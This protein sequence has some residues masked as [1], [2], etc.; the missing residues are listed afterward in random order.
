MAFISTFM[1]GEVGS[2]VRGII[3]QLVGV[4]NGSGWASYHDT[5]YSSG[6]PFALAG[7]D[8]WTTLPNN[9]GTTID[10]QAPQD[11]SV[12]YDPATLKITG[13]TG[14]AQT[15]T[16]EITGVPSTGTATYLDIAI[17]IG[18]AIGRVFPQTISFPRGAGVERSFTVTV[19]LY[20][21]ATWEANGGTIEVK[22]N[23][24]INLYGMRYN[25]I[26]SHKA[27]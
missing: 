3:N 2:A 8:T 26:R 16:L 9:A 18:G 23:A 11:E 25:I 24:N 19:A 12:L 7:N 1:N 27:R 13:R 15:I 20:N 6:A 21:L 5:Q 4:A 14:D 10:E 17:N 22:A